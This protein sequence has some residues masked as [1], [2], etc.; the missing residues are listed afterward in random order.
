MQF[1][2][3]AA[4]NDLEFAMRLTFGRPFAAL[5]TDSTMHVIEPLPFLATNTSFMRL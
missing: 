1:C 4:C 5:S 2:K 3:G